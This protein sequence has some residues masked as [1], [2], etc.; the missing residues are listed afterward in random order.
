[1]RIIENLGDTEGFYHVAG[2]LASGNPAA[3]ILKSKLEQ[4]LHRTFT[5]LSQLE[6]PYCFFA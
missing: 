4:L 1:M 2:V 3:L 5:M 6:I